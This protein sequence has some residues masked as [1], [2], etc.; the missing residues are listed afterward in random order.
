MDI[1]IMDEN[2]NKLPDG[3]KGE[4]IIA[5]PSVSKGLRNFNG[6]DGNRCF[7][8]A[9]CIEYTGLRKTV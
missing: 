4:I 7:S 1:F 6:G 2:G 5:G 8:R 3:E 9:V